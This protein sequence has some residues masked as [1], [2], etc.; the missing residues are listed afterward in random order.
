MCLQLE[1]DAALVDNLGRSF[2]CK[3]DQCVLKR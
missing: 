2:F 3:L 1:L